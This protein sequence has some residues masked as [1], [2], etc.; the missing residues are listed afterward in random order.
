MPLTE[1][2]RKQYLKQY[3][4]LVHDKVNSESPSCQISPWQLG[5]EAIC[6]SYHIL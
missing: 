3:L 5:P 2:V 6:I 4:I 1:T